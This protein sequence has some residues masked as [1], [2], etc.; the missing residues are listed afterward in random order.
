MQQNAL[1]FSDYCFYSCD[2]QTSIRAR[3]HKVICDRI[4]QIKEQRLLTMTSSRNPQANKS[5]FGPTLPAQKH[6]LSATRQ[7]HAAVTMAAK[8]YTV[9]PLSIA[10]NTLEPIYIPE[11]HYGLTTPLAAARMSLARSRKWM[12]LS[13]YRNLTDLTAD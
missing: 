6:A 7:R 10:I 1:R 9:S 12:L 2:D 8:D 11:L 4:F 5:F 13:P 3:F